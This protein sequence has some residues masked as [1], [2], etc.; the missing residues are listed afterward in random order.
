MVNSMLDNAVAIVSPEDSAII[1]SYRGAHYRWPG[2]IQRMKKAKLVR[3]MSKKS[4]SPDN[5][6]CEGFFGR[7]KNEFFYD[8]YWKT[9]SIKQFPTELDSYILLY[10]QNESNVLLVA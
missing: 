4:Y 5:S 7:L 3:S 10:I 1:H 8:H 2:W 6:A 9:F